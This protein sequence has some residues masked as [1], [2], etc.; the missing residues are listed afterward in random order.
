VSIDVDSVQLAGSNVSIWMRL[1]YA[2]P[3]AQPSGP[4]VSEMWG[5]QVFHCGQYQWSLRAAIVF[6]ARS[7]PIDSQHIDPSQATREAISP[8]GIDDLIY[9]RVCK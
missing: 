4:P 1:R 3:R 5:Q 7:R 9:R 8:E 6:D 2:V